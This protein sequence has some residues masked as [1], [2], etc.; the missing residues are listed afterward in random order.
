MDI[1]TSLFR[2]KFIINEKSAKSKSLNLICPS[3]RMA[4]DL[5]TG[6]TFVIRTNNMHSCVRM[7]ALAI[8]D[9]EKNNVVTNDWE[10]LWNKSLNLY[11]REYNQ[12]G[13]VAIYNEGDNIFSSGKHHQLFDVIEKC[14]AVNNESYEDS[15]ILAED[16]F[17]KV[18]KKIDMIYD[19]NVALVAILNGSNGRCSI[20]LRG[21]SKN[22]TFNYSMKPIDK[23]QDLDIYQGLSAAADFL[24]AV[25]LAYMVGVNNAKLSHG[26]IKRY[27]DEDKQSMKALD[28]IAV[29]NKKIN[30][31]EKIY[32]IHYRPERPNFKRIISLSEAAA[33]SDL[34]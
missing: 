1:D 21:I 4:I 32:S 19:S 2:E 20:M 27:S 15:I 25:Q 28:R 11:E 10:E 8:R 6:E 9:Y 5:P 24:E 29:L 26:L 22:T 23:S 18:G 14:D 17:A 31:M 30:Q 13:W 7:A 34:L 12:D 33:K 16:Y 3:T